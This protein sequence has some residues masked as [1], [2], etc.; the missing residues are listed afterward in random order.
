MPQI[1]NCIPDLISSWP[2]APDNVL[3]IRWDVFG[4]FHVT[5]LTLLTE[6]CNT[7]LADCQ[8]AISAERLSSVALSALLPNPTAACSPAPART[9]ACRPRRPSA[10][11][12]TR[13]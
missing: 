3:F 6:K 8:V 7:Q 11:V 12:R 4:Q 5:P 13:P 1:A 9:P 2:D 10:G